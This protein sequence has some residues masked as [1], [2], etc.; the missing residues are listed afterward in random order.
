MN[1]AIL[2]GDINDNKIVDVL[3]IVTKTLSG[4]V[5]MDVT[6]DEVA[7]STNTDLVCNVARK[8]ELAVIPGDLDL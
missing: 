5:W 1:I 6:D 7:S 3:K 4:D 8:Y 2:I